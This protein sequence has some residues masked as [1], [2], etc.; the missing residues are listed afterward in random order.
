MVMPCGTVVTTVTAVKS[1][2]RFD[3]GRASP[4]SPESP[5]KTP[6]KV[7]VIEKDISIQAMSCHG[8]PVSKTFSSSDTELLML[9]GSDPVA[10]VAIRQLSESSKLKVKSPRKKST[11]IISGVSKVGRGAAFAV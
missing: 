2:P 4:L 1:K 5:L 11:I 8:A 9:S 10:A 3:T 7:K 6:V